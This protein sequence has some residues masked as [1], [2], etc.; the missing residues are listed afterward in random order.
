M[1]HSRAEG[2][3]R[4]QLGGL[5]EFDLQALAL[6]DVADAA[7]QLNDPPVVAAKGHQDGVPGVHPGGQLDGVFVFNRFAGAQ[8]G[9]VA[10]SDLGHDRLG[11]DLVE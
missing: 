9:S 4:G 3:Q 7:E 1:S 8:A 6:G 10:L 5:D 11:Q 2:S